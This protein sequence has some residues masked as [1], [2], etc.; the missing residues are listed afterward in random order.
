[1]SLFLQNPALLG[2]LA[3][4]GVPV[5]VHLLSRAKPPQYRFSNTEF[6]RKVMRLTS[7]FRRPKDWLL[8]ALR[9]L[10]LLALAGA[11]LGPLLLSKDAPLPGEKRTLVLLIDRSASMAAKEGAASRFEAAC[12]EAGETLANIK[13]DL[14]NIVWIDAAPDAVFPD[15]A[16]NRDFLEEELS[17]AAVRPEP[18]ALEAAFDLALRQLREAGGRKELLLVSDFQ[19]AAWKD[20][21]PVLPG[22]VSLRCMPVAEADVP[23]VAVSSLV[24]LP[25]APVAGQQMLV[26]CRVANH[27]G[28]ARRVSLTLDAGGSR[29]SQALDLPARGEA[30]AAF[31]VRCSAPGLMPLSA[32][33]DADAFPA[34]DRRHGVVRVRESLRLAAAAP[35]DDAATG[36]LARAARALPW[37][38]LVPGVDPASLPACEILFVP[39]ARDADV[40]TLRR[41]AAEGT[42]VLASAGPQLS[43]GGVAALFGDS[44][45]AAGGM[46]AWQESDA[47]WEAAPAAEHAAFR[48][49]SGGGFGNPL[50]GKSKRR[51]GLVAPPSATVA[52]RFADGVPALLEAKDRP[53][54]LGNLPLDPAFSTWPGES[55]FLPAM[56][57]LLLYLAPRAASGSYE[58]EAGAALAWT[59]PSADPSGQP[60]LEAPDGSRPELLATGSTWRTEVPAVPGIYR[61]LVSGQPV[62]YTAVNFPVEESL[63]APMEQPPLPGGA[64]A[65]DRSAARRAALEE[66]LPLRP[67]LLALALACLLAE[68]LVTILKSRSNSPQPA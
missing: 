46:L 37:L 68:G 36:T 35:A 3:L 6:L 12:A 48:L 50:A 55:S 27:S 18:G 10:A 17:R 9:T 31:T 16:P 40:E 59:N 26:Q 34:D 4:A 44:S 52:A 7:R 5:L 33:I 47:G 49:F 63:L 30:E 24:P 67:W 1:M 29:Q 62:H 42:A 61:W 38:E 13:P 2:L 23:N 51:I 11:F 15:P 54:M 43:A 60:V 65:G 20:F 25:S 19:A 21:S 39:A 22:D 28:E 32:E 14:A 56:G 64:A 45:P 53:L 58:V 8:L 66:G 41:L 57:E